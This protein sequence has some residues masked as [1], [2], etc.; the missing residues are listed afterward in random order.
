MYYDFCSVMS[1]I[2]NQQQNTV[3][4]LC[5]KTSNENSV[6]KPGLIISDLK[7]PTRI[8]QA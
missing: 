4:E 5:G 3:V 8:E 2:Q 1:G 6:R 7:S